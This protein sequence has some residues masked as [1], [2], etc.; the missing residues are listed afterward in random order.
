[1]YHK[2]CSII[3]VLESYSS[4]YFLAFKWL[5]QNYRSSYSS[6]TLQNWGNQQTNIKK[7]T[8]S[9]N[10]YQFKE[11]MKKPARKEF[12]DFNKEKLPI[13]WYCLWR[14]I[15]RC[16]SC[17]RSFWQCL[18]SMGRLC[19]YFHSSDLSTNLS[20]LSTSLRTFIFQIFHMI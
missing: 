10:K 11:N 9:A 20:R 14:K 5:N 17:L 4:I 6:T 12:D 15:Q 16:F 13:F 2:I 8:F 1:M 7:N 18:F 19:Y 3:H